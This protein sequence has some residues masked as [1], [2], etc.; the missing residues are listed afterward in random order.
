LM[1]KIVDR[2]RDMANLILEIVLKHA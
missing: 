2:Q 1:E